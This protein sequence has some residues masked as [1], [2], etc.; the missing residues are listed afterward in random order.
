MSGWQNS[1]HMYCRHKGSNPV[2]FSCMR[3]TAAHDP[4]SISKLAARLWVVACVNAR[5]L[6]LLCRCVL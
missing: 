6:N 1:L 5:L 2:E 3:N 4:N